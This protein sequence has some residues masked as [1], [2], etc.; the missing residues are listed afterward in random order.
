MNGFM[1][2]SHK[3]HR[4]SFGVSEYLCS[5]SGDVL[6]AF[7]Y[8]VAG[9]GI[10]RWA[11]SGCAPLRT[12]SQRCLLCADARRY[13]PVSEEGIIERGYSKP[14]K[15]KYKDEVSLRGGL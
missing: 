3:P 9:N 13:S 2:G 7:S 1:R 4:A 14:G 8:P 6:D 11:A 10:I 12:A 15:R 5:R